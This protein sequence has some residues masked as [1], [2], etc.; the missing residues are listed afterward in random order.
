[1]PLRGSLTCCV[2]RLLRGVP[3]LTRLSL[4]DMRM[5][6]VSPGLLA[7]LRELRVLNVSGNLL[8]ALHPSALHP[9]LKLDTVD[10]SR[11]QLQGLDEQSLLRLDAVDLVS[12][13]DVGCRW[14]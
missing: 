10:V 13:W 6:I 1:M 2:C 14:W 12:G 4:A 3:H 8:T 11:N 7:P 5:R 9:L